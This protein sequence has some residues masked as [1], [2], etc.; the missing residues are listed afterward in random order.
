MKSSYLKGGFSAP[1]SV[2]KLM[3]KCQKTVTKILT[4]GKLSTEAIYDAVE[5]VKEYAER[6]DKAIERKWFSKPDTKDPKLTVESYAEA[7]GGGDKELQT[8]TTVA[9]LQAGESAILA[10]G[11]AESYAATEKGETYVNTFSGMTGGDTAA[12]HTYYE[13]GANYE[14]ALEVLVGIDWKSVY[15]REWVI[16][17]HHGFHNRKQKELDDG[18]K[19][20]SSNIA[21]VEAESYAQ[22]KQSNIAMIFEKTASAYSQQAVEIG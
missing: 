14:K 17:K 13:K 15:D 9:M 10:I 18:V 16:K 3:L 19:V 20:V 5:T 11:T 21:Y 2:N 12:I 8:H 7:T 4:K 6:I 22:V 1:S